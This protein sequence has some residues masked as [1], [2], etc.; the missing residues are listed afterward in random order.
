M[1]EQLKRNWKSLKRGQ[2]G[3][4]FQDQYERQRKAQSSRAGRV[5]RILGGAVLL[6]LGLFFLPAPGPG[7]II[8]ALGGT[9]LARELKV[10]AIV[11]DWLELRG[12]SVLTWAKR[13][14][15]RLVRARRTVIR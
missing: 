6:L 10:A 9:L 11:L 14:W 13:T 3:S 1:F 12:R 2:P 8:V 15:Q 7:F 5:L 4:R